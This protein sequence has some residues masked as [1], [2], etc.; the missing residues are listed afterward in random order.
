[1]IL[2]AF[3]KNH[4][5][6]NLYGENQIKCISSTEDDIQEAFHYEHPME[7]M[8]NETFGHYR[9]EDTNLGRTQPLG[10]N[11]VLNES[12]REDHNEFIEFL[13][14]GNQTLC[15]GSKYKKN[16]VCNKIRSHQ[17]FVWIK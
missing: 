12:P 11:D 1:L 6:W 5:I 13:N 9:Q 2:K 10:V 14:H 15:G 7:T 3:S 4:V 17:G 16:R 8:I